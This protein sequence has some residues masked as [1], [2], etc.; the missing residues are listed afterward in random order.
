MHIYLVAEEI[1]V[2][3]VYV[4][5]KEDNKY[6]FVMPHKY[7]KDLEN[8]KNAWFPII[9]FTSQRK[10]KDLAKAI[11]IKGTDFVKEFYE[12]QKAICCQI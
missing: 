3:G 7:A 1:D 10:N 4:F 11:Y 9:N 2:R 12:K 8:G 5:K 6:K